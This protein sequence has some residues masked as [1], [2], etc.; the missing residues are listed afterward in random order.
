MFLQS[1]FVVVD[2]KAEHLMGIRDTLG[3][4][5]YDCHTILY[6]DEEVEDWSPFPGLRILFIDKNLRTGVTVGGADKNAFATIADV[7]QRVVDPNGGP[8][9]LILW[10]EEPDLD[11]FKKFLNERFSAENPNLV[12]VFCDQLTKAEYIDTTNGAVKDHEKFKKDIVEKVSSCAP[13][14]A[15]FSWE[16]DVVAAMDAVLRSIVDLT[17]HQSRTTEE[18]SAEL[19]KVLFHLSRAGSGENKAL[20]SPRESINR[21]L[22]PILADRIAEHDPDGDAHVV[23]SEA[24][25]EPSQKPDASIRA[26]VNSAIHIS[27][28]ASRKSTKI[29]PSDLGAVLEFPFKNPESAMEEKFGISKAMLLSDKFFGM[30]E[31]DWG[32]CLL[33]LVQIGAACDNAQPKPGTLIYLLGLEWPFSSIDGNKSGDSKL[34]KKKSAKTEQEWRSPVILVG[35]K[36]SPGVLSVFRNCSISIPREQ[37]EKWNPRYRLREELVAQLTQSYARHTSR[38]GVVQL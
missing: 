1:R 6:D 29:R 34:Y 10:A 15:L 12:P 30:T 24:L 22:V 14:R 2:D 31:E 20:E 26:V 21:V 5:R 13:L 27:R 33:R 36:Q 8:Y 25:V 37:V 11:E 16:T 38:L 18:F 7:I 23:W 28:A 19:G 32:N 9:G 17:P 35:G 4:L 3:S